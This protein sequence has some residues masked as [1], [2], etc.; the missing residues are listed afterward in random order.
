VRQD[1]PPVAERFELFWK[2]LELANGFGE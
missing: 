2:G 1:H